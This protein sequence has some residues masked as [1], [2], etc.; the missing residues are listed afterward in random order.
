MCATPDSPPPPDG[1][2]PPGRRAGRGDEITPKITGNAPV[3]PARRRAEILRQLQERER[4]ERLR[5]GV[6][7]EQQ[8]LEAAAALPQR[9]EEEQRE[10]DATV[11]ALRRELQSTAFHMETLV[12][13]RAKLVGRLTEMGVDAGGVEAF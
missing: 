5:K 3:L 9:T 4:E 12:K 11:D 2:V 10:Y 7:D 1:Y 8:Q 6:P 13:R